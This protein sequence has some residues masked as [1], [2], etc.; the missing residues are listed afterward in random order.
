LSTIDRLV[1]VVHLLNMHNDA[2]LN[3]EPVLP[4]FFVLGGIRLY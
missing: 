4:V 3:I 2:V 1:R